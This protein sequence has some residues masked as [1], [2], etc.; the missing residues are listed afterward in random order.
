MF[1]N[2]MRRAAASPF[3]KISPLFLGFIHVV[4]EP[5]TRDTLIFSI[6]VLIPRVVYQPAI[7]VIFQL[8]SANIDIA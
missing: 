5:D 6:V 7:T 8:A 2:F 1:A 4:K 3:R